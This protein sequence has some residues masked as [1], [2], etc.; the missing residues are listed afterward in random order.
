[1]IKTQFINFEWRGHIVTIR[2]EEIKEV[3][4]LVKEH[5]I[6]LNRILL[7]SKLII[8]SLNSFDIGYHL[9]IPERRYG[10]SYSAKFNYHRKALKLIYEQNILGDLLLF[11]YLLNSCEHLSSLSKLK[12]RLDIVLKCFS[13][14]YADVLTQQEL[15]TDF[16]KNL[17]HFK[18][19]SSLIAEELTE[20]LNLHIPGVYV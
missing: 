14:N 8:T 6:L 16:E 4:E 1:M 17:K 2:D 18:S 10:Y 11:R 12:I 3:N 15:E 7:K 9:T 20:L 13:K 19:L 5:F